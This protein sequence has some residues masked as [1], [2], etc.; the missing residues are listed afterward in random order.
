MKG[1]F[2]NRTG[3]ELMDTGHWISVGAGGINMDTPG[4]VSFKYSETG[5]RI[6]LRLKPELVS[7]KGDIFRIRGF[8]FERECRGDH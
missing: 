6:R 4:G 3:T 8:S 7:D 5:K 1:V 2:T